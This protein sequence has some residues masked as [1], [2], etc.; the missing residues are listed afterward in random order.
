VA[1]SLSS[2][3]RLDVGPSL[4]VLS[5]FPLK[6]AES[7]LPRESGSFVVKFSGPLIR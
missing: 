6:L 4:S 3:V 1:L 7:A 2:F 5:T